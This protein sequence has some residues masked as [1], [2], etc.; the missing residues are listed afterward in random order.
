MKHK[1]PFLSSMLSVVIGM[2]IGIHGAFAIS[3]GTLLGKA[4]H[5]HFKMSTTITPQEYLPKTINFKINPKYRPYCRENGIEISTLKDFF[6]L[7]GGSVQ[8]MFPLHFAPE[9]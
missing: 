1:N 7:L 3:N 5:Q 6:Q 8:K 4:P 9:V 2:L